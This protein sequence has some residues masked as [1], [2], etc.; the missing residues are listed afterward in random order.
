MDKKID[1]S[2]TSLTEKQIEQVAGGMPPRA[3]CPSCSTA[4]AS[5]FETEVA[6]LTK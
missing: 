1:E 5:A 2:L 3:G 6:R 4:R